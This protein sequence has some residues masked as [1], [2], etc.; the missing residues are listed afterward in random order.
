MQQSHQQKQ[1]KTRTNIRYTFGINAR[2]FLIYYYYYLYRVAKPSR[3]E[4]TNTAMLT[5]PLMHWQ[6]ILKEG[7][8]QTIFS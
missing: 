6:G 1:N 4:H 8:Q 5:H 2:I 7:I 3:I